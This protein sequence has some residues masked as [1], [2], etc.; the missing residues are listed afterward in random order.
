M[1][2]E[3]NERVRVVK[4]FE[5]MNLREELLHG[6]Y[7]CGFDLPSEIQKRAILPILT[8]RD[9]I[10]QAQS[11]TGK[12]ATFSISLL[13]TVDCKSRD[14]Q[15]L[16]L[17]PT[18]ELALQIGGVIRSLGEYM[19]V[20]VQELVGGKSVGDDVKR[21]EQGVHVVSGTPGRVLDMIKR[22]HLR[23]KGIKIFIL[24]EA[25]EMLTAGYKDQIYDIFRYLPQTVQVV[26][27]SA[28]L[29]RVVLNIAN[30]F[31]EDPI[32]ILVRREEVTLDKIRQFFISV[33][34]EEWK[35]DTLCDLYD[36]MTI[37][38]AVIFCNLRRKVE[39]LAEQMRKQHFTVAHMHGDMS[40]T[41]R[42]AVMNS[43][44]SAEKRV[45]ITTDLWARGIDVP[46]VSLVINY[47]LPASKENYVH[48][49][50]RSGRF[51]RKGVAINFVTTEDVPTLRELE[52]HYKTRID[53]MPA[54][55]ADYL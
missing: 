53:E 45:L 8:K 41:E 16:V 52:R 1:K 12:T 10:C 48:R 30:S 49:I 27:V 21:L 38:Q 19:K 33:E 2:F 25:D 34:R 39:W 14:T 3:T 20:Q 6:I 11:G 55:V 28:T 9:C 7:E 15:A 36:T 43:F 51:G 42:E 35:F 24:D 22:N 47:D 54:R 31:M 5:Q 4:S 50:G 44:R 17:S 37:S 29:P 13:Q 23:V 46:Q 40:Q 18:R 26:L 32:R